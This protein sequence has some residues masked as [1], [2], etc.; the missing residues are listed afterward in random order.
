MFQRES[1]KRSMFLRHSFDTVIMIGIIV[2]FNVQIVAFV[3]QMNSSI[4]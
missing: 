2:I 3:T 4:T 1:W